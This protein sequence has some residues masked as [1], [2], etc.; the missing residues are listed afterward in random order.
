MVP[1]TLN[2]NFAG[3]PGLGNSSLG[4]PVSPSIFPESGEGQ[5]NATFSSV[6][7]EVNQT[8]GKVSTF[9]GSPSKPSRF[10]DLVGAGVSASF[11]IG[12][13]E[14]KQPQ[15]DTS[16]EP[17]SAPPHFPD[18]AGAEFRASFLGGLVEH[19]QPQ[20]DGSSG[21]EIVTEVEA[22]LLFP[23]EEQLEGIR[24]GVNVVDVNGQRNSRYAELHFV[25]HSGRFDSATYQ[26]QARLSEP[27]ILLGRNQS[28]TEGQAQPSISLLE[29]FSALPS[30]QAQMS[31]SERSTPVGSFDTAR[32]ILETP[33][34]L[35]SKGTQGQQNPAGTASFKPVVN[36]FEGIPLGD[37]L[38]TPGNVGMG[39][40][41][42]GTNPPKPDIPMVQTLGYEM[43][44]VKN[45]NQVSV[46]SMTGNVSPSPNLEEASFGRTG[47]E[48]RGGL[49]METSSLGQQ[50]EHGGGS[51]GT[52]TLFRNSAGNGMA[53]STDFQQNTPAT[54]G[55]GQ[56]ARGAHAF[57]ERLQTLN[58]VSPQKLQIDVQISEASRVQVDVA[59]QQRQVY[60]GLLL[61]QPALRNLAL[62]QVPQL[63]GQ[64]NQA[65]MELQEFDAELEGQL[66]QHNDTIRYRNEQAGLPGE[67]EFGLRQSGKKEE[68]V[69]RQQDMGLHFVV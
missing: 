10:P 6:F 22:D 15:V 52:D 45:G 54:V 55:Q 31:T 24:K 21:Q 19:K 38:V 39:T 60:A 7:G 65:G 3:L 59:V 36:S 18:L 20:A 69:D 32:G 16:F 67:S 11:L 61:D 44:A 27:G 58:S 57:D 63:E 37:A 35:S 8:Q 43:G 51:G 41:S 49:L 48:G 30:R 1:N 28:P 23:L 17:P 47:S 40:P 4:Q 68:R 34:T 29:T 9:S 12:L 2:N 64:L 56:A 25:A 53:S 50:P 26:N 46:V 62:Q 14:G 13:V 5:V 42:R 33:V 66:E